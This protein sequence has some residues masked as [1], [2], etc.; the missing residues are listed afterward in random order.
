[1]TE[2]G[3]TWQD[4]PVD[5]PQRDTLFVNQANA[6]LD[7]VEGKSAPMCPLEEGIAALNVNLAILSSMTQQ[8]WCAVEH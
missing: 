5:V 3:A 6:F 4:E 8:S 1:M 7:A 2:P